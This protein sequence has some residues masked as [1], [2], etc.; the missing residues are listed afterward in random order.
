MYQARSAG[1]DSRWRYGLAVFDPAE[2][3]VR[4]P[5]TV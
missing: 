2:M 3:H 5:L 1:H 4:E